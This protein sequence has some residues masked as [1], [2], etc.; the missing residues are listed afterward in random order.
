MHLEMCLLCFEFA[1]KYYLMKKNVESKF[2]MIL[3]FKLFNINLKLIKNV[4]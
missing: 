1:Y 2:F 4:L 3:Y